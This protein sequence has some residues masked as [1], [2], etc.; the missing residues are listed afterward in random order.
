ME[1]CALDEPIT[2]PVWDES[3]CENIITQPLYRQTDSLTDEDEQTIVLRNRQAARA[4]SRHGEPVSDQLPDLEITE[5]RFPRVRESRLSDSAQKMPP[6]GHF[7]RA[8]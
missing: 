5:R 6:T 7:E 3:A 4:Q 8:R 2:P 1:T